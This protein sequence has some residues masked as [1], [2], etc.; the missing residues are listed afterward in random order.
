MQTTS[1]LEFKLGGNKLNYRIDISNIL[2]AEMT[3]YPAAADVT[4][5]YNANAQ[6]KIS[7][8]GMYDKVITFDENK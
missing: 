8:F 1:T 5:L 7:A 4:Q 6:Y 2:D 3:A